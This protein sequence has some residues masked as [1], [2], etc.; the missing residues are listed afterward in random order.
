MCCSDLDPCQTG[1]G[2]TVIQYESYH[3][4]HI[5]SFWKYLGKPSKGPDGKP[6]APLSIVV[7]PSSLVKNW[8]NEFTKWLGDRVST[9]AIDGGS[10][11]DIDTKLESFCSQTVTGRVHTPV[12]FMNEFYFEIQILWGLWNKIELIEDH[13]KHSDYMH[14]S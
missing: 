9:V 7:S 4:N 8:Q 14:M 12:L 5:F 1:I 6:I 10:K 2:F 11:K 13:T 3:F